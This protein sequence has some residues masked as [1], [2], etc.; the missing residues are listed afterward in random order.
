MMRTIK[1]TAWFRSLTSLML[2]MAIVPA[3]FLLYDMPGA[4]FIGEVWKF[5]SFGVDGI[6]RPSGG[7]FNARQVRLCT[8]VR[9]HS[10]DHLRLPLPC[11]SLSSMNPS[12]RSTETAMTSLAGSSSRGR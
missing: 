2:G 8:D 10:L 3:S 5:M 4:V 6:I 12:A 11:D 7:G 9:D 1:Q